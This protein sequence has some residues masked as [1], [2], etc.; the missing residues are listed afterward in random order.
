M[1][2][3]KLNLIGRVL[4]SIATAIGSA[5]ATEIQIANCTPQPTNP[6]IDNMGA[7]FEARDDANE[8]YDVYDGSFLGSPYDYALEISS[9]EP[10]FKASVNAKP[11]N[12]PY[13]EFDLGFFS[14]SGGSYPGS[15]DNKLRLKVK[16]AGGLEYRK[17]IAYDISKDLSDPNNIHEVPKNGDIL[18]VPL[19]YLVNPEPGVYA[20]WHIATPSLVPGDVA[21]AGAHSV[22]ALDGKVDIYDL[23]VIA[24]EWLYETFEGENY[25]WGDLNYDGINNF[26]DFGIMANSWLREE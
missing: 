23:E 7:Y 12:T 9:N 14:R 8:K 21:S 13:A 25:S 20:T 2:G 1:E 3:R 17:V 22:G 15:I 18:E 16:D 4:L 6:K 10:G 19:E 26:R 24:D 11:F 5:N